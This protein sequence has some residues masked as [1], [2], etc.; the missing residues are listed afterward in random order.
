MVRTVGEGAQSFAAT[1]HRCRVPT[2]HLLESAKPS[3]RSMADGFAVL[4]GRAA[5]VVI[6][7]AIA[8]QTA[9]WRRHGTSIQGP[10]PT[11]ESRDSNM[12]ATALEPPCPVKDKW[13]R[14]ARG[15]YEVRYESNHIEMIVETKI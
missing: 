4:G 3:V 2:R 9:V 14:E 12:I 6:E 7:P 8:E 15:E 11:V 1:A 10:V 13:L 5:P